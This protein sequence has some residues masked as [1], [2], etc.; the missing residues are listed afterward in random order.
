[1]IIDKG[2]NEWAEAQK[3][4]IIYIYEEAEK[5]FLKKFNVQIS[6]TK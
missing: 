4:A 5:N 1:M 3:N 6:I 2:I